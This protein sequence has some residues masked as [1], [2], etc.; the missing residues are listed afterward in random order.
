MHKELFGQSFLTGCPFAISS[1]QTGY[2]IYSQFSAVLVGWHF[3]N[4]ILNEIN[5]MSAGVFFD[6]YTI[7][8][9]CSKTSSVNKN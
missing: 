1:P 8:A 2:L 6:R 9:K 7:V 4:T 3:K 5:L